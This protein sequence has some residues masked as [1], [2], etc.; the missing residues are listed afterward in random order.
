MMNPANHHPIIPLRHS[1]ATHAA[2]SGPPTEPERKTGASHAG[3]A[4]GPAP[5]RVAERLGVLREFRWSSYRGYAGYAAPVVWVW[6]QPLAR[7]C[8]GRAELQQR[9]APRQY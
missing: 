2:S 9:A 7:L 3:L 1:G 4:R 8:G 5:E 6:R